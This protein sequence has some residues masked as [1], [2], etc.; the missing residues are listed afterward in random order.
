LPAAARY[1]PIIAPIDTLQ[2]QRQDL[3]LAVEIDAAEELLSETGRGIFRRALCATAD[4]S[5]VT[6]WRQISPLG[7]GD[8]IARPVLH[9][10]RA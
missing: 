2:C 4:F 6:M 3:R 7:N 5:S 8:T 9:A 10:P 1:R